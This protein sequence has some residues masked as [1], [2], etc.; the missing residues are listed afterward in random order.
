MRI[1]LPAMRHPCSPFR[2]DPTVVGYLSVVPGAPQV[3]YV[4]FIVD[5]FS[6]MIVGWRATTNMRTTMVLDALEMARWSRGTTLEGLVC[7]SDA[8]SSPRSATANGSPSSVPCPRSSPRWTHRGH[9]RRQK[10]PYEAQRGRTQTASFPRWERVSPH[11]AGCGPRG[12]ALL[13]AVCPRGHGGSSPPSRTN[14]D[15]RKRTCSGW[16]FVCRRV[17]VQA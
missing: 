9:K 5:A 14:P 10:W 11:E 6:R 12:H 15:Q 4:C 13:R 2:S 1:L 3:V 8:G 17:T 7:H 16:P